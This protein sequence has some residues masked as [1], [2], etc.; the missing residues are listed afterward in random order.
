M[1]NNNL[2]K[3]LEEKLNLLK[4]YERMR[5]HEIETTGHLS[6]D[7]SMYQILFDKV[8]KIQKEIDLIQENIKQ[9]GI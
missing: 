2:E 1:E 8:E 4:D 7:V 5:F 6:E 9:K 3:L